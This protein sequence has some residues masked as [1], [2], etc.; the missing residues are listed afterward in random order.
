MRNLKN[1]VAGR[2]VISILATQS[3]LDAAKLM[4]AKNVGAALVMNGQ[5]LDGIVTERD[6]IK[7]IVALGRN[8][9]TVAVSEIMTGN[10][11][12]MAADKPFVRALVA[13]SEGK[14]RHIPVVEGFKV[15]GVVSIRD[16]IGSEHEQMDRMI[17]ALNSIEGPT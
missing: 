9:E 17:Q 6:I 14:F 16:A 15:I 11:V 7:K 1:V 8:P 13:M 5:R 4:A 10:P 2:E 3:V 12:V